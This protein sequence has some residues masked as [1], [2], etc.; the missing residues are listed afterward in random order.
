MGASAQPKDMG[1]RA[2]GRGRHRFD[3][4]MPDAVARTEQQDLVSQE[5]GE[6]PGG[7]PSLELRNAVN[8]IDHIF[9]FHKALRR[10]LLRLVADA[11]AFSAAVHAALPAPPPTHSRVRAA[12]EAVV[13]LCSSAAIGSAVSAPTLQ[14]AAGAQEGC[15]CFPML[16]GRS[17]GRLIG[18]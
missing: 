7:G 11:A 1:Y 10:D 9:Q 6:A 13:H 8:P 12:A 14:T 15:G 2:L 16:L 17:F 5:G 18:D 4:R 3:P